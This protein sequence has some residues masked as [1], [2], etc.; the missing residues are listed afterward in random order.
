M[1]PR[2][3]NHVTKTHPNSRIGE[4]RQGSKIFNV[5]ARVCEGGGH[6]SV[7]VNLTGHEAGNG[8]H[9]QGTPAD[10]IVAS[11]T[12]KGCPSSRG[13]YCRALS[14]V[15]L[16]GS[17]RAGVRFKA[18]SGRNTPIPLRCFTGAV[19]NESIGSR[20]PLTV[21]RGGLKTRWTTIKDALRATDLRTAGH[22]PL[23]SVQA[24]VLSARRRG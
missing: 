18:R 24:L 14:Y 3:N 17:S 21:G 19:Q 22:H 15:N 5:H 10:S 7:T 12:R 9:R 11:S 23:A 20:S 2:S 6:D 13:R 4:G 16:G 8:G 1:S